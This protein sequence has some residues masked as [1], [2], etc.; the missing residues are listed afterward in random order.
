MSE[1]QLDFAAGGTIHRFAHQAM[2]TVFEIFIAHEDRRYAEQAAFACFAEFD[3]LERELSRFIE[4]SDIARLRRLATGETVRVGLDAFA[5]LQA[6][7]Q[8]HADTGGAFDVTVGAL[9]RCWFGPDRALRTPAAADIEAALQQVGLDRLRLDESDFSVS[10][11]GEAALELDL[12]GFGKGYALDVAAALLREWDIEVALLHSGFSSVLALQAPAGQEGWPL[13]LRHPAARG[14]V[15]AR[16]LLA[17]CALSASGLRK[18]QHIIDP[19]TGYPAAGEWLASWVVGACA[20]TCDGLSTAFMLLSA[21]EIGAYCERRAGAGA[22]C[23]S[24]GG[25]IHCWGEWEWR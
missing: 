9:L 13:V 15:L 22:L 19:R 4:N 8:L 10:C 23:L 3:R 21:D 20:A 14:R 1:M 2:A 18:G 16:P 12:G 5:C 6:C 7:R 17:Q 11:D 25:E 24:H